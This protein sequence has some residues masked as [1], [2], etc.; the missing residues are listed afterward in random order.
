MDSI[1]LFYG[2]ET[3]NTERIAFAIADK[4]SLPHEHIFNVGIT[5]DVIPIMMNYDILIIGTSTW[6]K[7]YLAAAWDK[8]YDDLCR[9]NFTGT[10]V[11]LF[12]LGNQF[13]Y[14]FT[15]LDGM[16]D[17]AK[18]FKKNG[19]ILVGEWPNDGYCF[20]ESQADRGDGFFYGLGIDEDYQSELTEQ[21]I[22]DWVK[23][24]QCQ[25]IFIFEGFK[26]VL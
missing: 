26:K 4:L 23:L 17:L 21:R 25:F 1:G 2:S 6:R 9:T 10:N 16:G 12:G 24:L 22:I 14:N 18:V 8:L 20:D 19:A 7:G 13:D 5:K 11:A 3:D 15:Y